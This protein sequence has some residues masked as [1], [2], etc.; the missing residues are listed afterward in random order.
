MTA[1]TLISRDV[2]LPCLQRVV[3]LVPARTTIPVL[4]CIRLEHDAGAGLLRLAANNTQAEI[5]ATLKAQSGGD[6]SACVDARKLVDFT[7]SL[8]RDCEVSIAASDD[9]ALVTIRGGGASARLLALPAEEF[10]HATPPPH[11]LPTTVPAAELA[12]AL[13]F[14]LPSVSTEELVRH[15][16]CGV[17]LDGSAGDYAAVSS[18]GHRLARHRLPVLHLP[19]RGVIVPR[20]TCEAVLKLLGDSDVTVAASE[21]VILVSGKG[22]S[23][24]SKVIDGQYSDWRRAV[25]PHEGVPLIVDREDFAAAVE[26][27]ADVESGKSRRVTLER[28]GGG[29]LTVSG[30]EVTATVD[31]VLAVDGGPPEI[32]TAF[33]TKYLPQAIAVVDP[34]MAQIE[35]ELHPE[36]ASWFSG[37]GA[38]A[39]GVHIM[40]MR[41]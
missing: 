33:N 22:W 8:K 26:R 16:L 24:T 11:A 39:D 31:T 27:V 36:S 21:R 13:R 40:G 7:A 17:F 37:P 4:A 15:H 30:G 23:I 20:A 14:C 41:V 5:A 10:P 38:T 34:D 9:G 2:L 12:A 25:P 1:S 28:T 32:H 3:S 18:D 6:W 29:D 19:E 35:I